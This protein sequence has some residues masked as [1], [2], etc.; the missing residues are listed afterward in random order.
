MFV[1]DSGVEL[2]V[3]RPVYAGP[4]ESFFFGEGEIGGDEWHCDLRLGP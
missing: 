3:F 4:L 2:V 1:V